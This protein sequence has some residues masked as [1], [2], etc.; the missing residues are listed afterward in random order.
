MKIFILEDDSY[1]ITTFIEKFYDHELTITE[2]AENAIEYLTNNVYDVIFLDNDLG[3]DNGFGVDVATFLYENP[4]NQNNQ[5]TI[6]VHSW[7]LIATK[8]ILSKLD[9]ARSIP[10]NSDEF[11]TLSLFN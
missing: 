4:Q 1:R 8:N 6:I 5:T 2:K 9:N 3:Y 10:F 7:N 11:N